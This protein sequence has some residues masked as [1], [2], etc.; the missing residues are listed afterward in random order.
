MKD[1]KLA[2]PS[3]KTYFEGFDEVTDYEDGMTLRQYYKG[4]ALTG[5]ISNQGL[6]KAV[7]DENEDG[8]GVAERVS[9][10]AGLY[11]DKMLEEEEK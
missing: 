8:D 9:T 6:M 11:A 5:I 7:C 4:Q 3:K 2:F 1:E 10:L